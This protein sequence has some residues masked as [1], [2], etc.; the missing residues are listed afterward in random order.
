MIY[1]YGATFMGMTES[2]KN[3]ILDTCIFNG[4]YLTKNDYE[5][6]NGYSLYLAKFIYLSLK[7][8]YKN[9]YLLKITYKM[10]VKQKIIF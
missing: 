8:N 9:Y 7:T 4:N 6:L 3:T 5:N 10:Y 2:I 1:L